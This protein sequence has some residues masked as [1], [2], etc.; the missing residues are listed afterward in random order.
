M[1]ESALNHATVYFLTISFLF[2]VG[3]ILGWVLELFYRRFFSKN[4]PDRKWINP[5]FLTG[6]YVPLYGFGLA[7]LFLMSDL[8][9][10]GID[11]LSDLT[12][13]KTLL[14][15]LFMGIMMTLIE[16]IAGWIFIK[17]MHVKLWDYSNERFNLQGI[18]CPK[19][20]L[21]WTILG[22]LYY[23]FIQPHV[24]KL[25]AWYFNNIAFSFIVGMFFGIFLIDFSYSVQ[26]VRKI[27]SYAK[28]HEIVVRYEELKSSIR[29]AAEE[30]REKAHFLLAF[31]SEQPLLT[32][33]EEYRKKLLDNIEQAR[34]DLEDNLNAVRD[35][36]FHDED[37]KG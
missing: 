37:K 5:G 11:S 27:Q 3:S 33:L 2:F 25:V 23:F 13:L 24:V 32:H 20:S 18:I 28:E 34:I 1:Q 31:Q 35:N 29:T 4:N 26:I 8:P 10:L 12:W 15:I 19:F 6:P 30:A 21:Y 16:Y 36:L 7:I 9:Y 22:A 17:K 14:C